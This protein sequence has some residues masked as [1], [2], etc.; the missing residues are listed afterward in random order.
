MRALGWALI[1]VGMFVAGWGIYGALS[2]LAETY[3][4]ALD[5]PLGENETDEKTDLPRTMLVHAGIGA[6]GVLPGV[7]GLFMLRGAQVRH[8]HAVMRHEAAARQAR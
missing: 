1:L 5:D 8:K 2:A 7:P 3:Q 4:H 6:L